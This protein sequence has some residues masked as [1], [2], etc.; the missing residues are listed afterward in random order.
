MSGKAL[1]ITRTFPDGIMRKN[2]TINKVM[3][4]FPG[5]VTLAPDS[6]RVQVEGTRSSSNVC[7]GESGG[8]SVVRANNKPFQVGSWLKKIIH[9]SAI[10]SL[11]TP[12]DGF[13]INSPKRLQLDQRNLGFNVKLQMKILDTQ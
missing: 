10:N 11:T 4:T 13:D 5:Y 9:G 3:Q 1:V 8:A 12:L 7:S 2:S 6:S